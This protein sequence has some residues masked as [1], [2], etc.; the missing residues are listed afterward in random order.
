MVDESTRSDNT[1]RPETMLQS[2]CPNLT[3][4]AHCGW[5]SFRSSS[6]HHNCSTGKNAAYIVDILHVQ[7]TSA[8][9]AHDVPAGTQAASTSSDPCSTEAEILV[10]NRGTIHSAPFERKFCEPDPLA[11]R[12]SPILVDS[13]LLGVHTHQSCTL[14]FGGET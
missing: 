10:W 4:L 13:N 14:H 12:L 6:G 8:S 2:L 9:F 1:P 11:L 5:R 3:E 7:H